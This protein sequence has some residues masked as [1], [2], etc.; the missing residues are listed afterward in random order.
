MKVK[1]NF[2]T[3]AVLFS[4]LQKILRNRNFIF[5]VVVILVTIYL[6]HLP[7]LMQNYFIH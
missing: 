7:T 5:F 2:Q 6:F 3:A 4:I 1:E